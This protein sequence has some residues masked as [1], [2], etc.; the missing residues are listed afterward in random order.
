MPLDG[1]MRQK[2]SARM[3]RDIDASPNYNPGEV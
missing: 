2:T 3:I 1:K